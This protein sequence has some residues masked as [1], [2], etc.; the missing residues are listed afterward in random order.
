MAGENM[1]PDHLI[2]LAAGLVAAGILGILALRI[3]GL[4]QTG[5]ALSTSKLQ[6]FLW[7][8][9]AL[10]TYAFLFTAYAIH[11]PGDVLKFRP[12]I[13][14]HVLLLLGLSITAAAASQA[15]PQPSQ[16]K[17]DKALLCIFEDANEERS[18]PKVQMRACTLVAIGVYLY[19]AVGSY[20][21][22]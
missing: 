7:T 17:T 8:E 14:E 11:N 18:L 13:P 2:A 19:G 4:L 21:N 5:G 12:A 15:K 6:F 3:P 16:V 1:D 22:A 9:A 20:Y 10:F